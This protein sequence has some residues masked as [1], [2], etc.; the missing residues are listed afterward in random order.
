LSIQFLGLEEFFRV[1]RWDS[2]SGDP[3]TNM[4]NSMTD[5][6]RRWT[7]VYLAIFVFAFAGSL[8]AADSTPVTLPRWC[9]QMQYAAAKIR[10]G[11]SKLKTDDIRTT[12]IEQIADSQAGRTLRVRSKV[13]EVTWKE[14]VATI[15]I[16]PEIPKTKPLP[17]TPL[18]I[19]RVLNFDI[20][21]T[22][23]EALAIRSGAA[24]ELTGV[25]QFHPRRWGAVG[26][27][28]KSQQLYDLRHEFLGGGYLG[29]FTTQS[30]DVAIGGKTYPGAWNVES[31]AP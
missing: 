18:R 14:G 23:E 19:N 26:T 2:L 25:L 13:K 20:K 22:K 28:T 24:F 29:T 10:P 9:A 12:Y 11:D 15:T 1:S 17:R 8:R 16:E 4:A 7:T 5:I 6:E 3:A 21:A 31:P 27:A 30:Y